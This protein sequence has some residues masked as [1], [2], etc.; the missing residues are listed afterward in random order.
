MI[1]TAKLRQSTSGMHAINSL[2]VRRRAYSARERGRRAYSAPEQ[3]REKVVC[4]WGYA[5]ARL[6]RANAGRCICRLILVGAHTL[7]RLA[8]KDER[9]VLLSGEDER[10]ALLGQWAGKTGSDAWV[11]RGMK[12]LMCESTIYLFARLA[13]RWAYRARQRMAG[14]FGCVS[15]LHRSI[16]NGNVRAYNQALKASQCPVDLNRIIA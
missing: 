6:G 3:T 16:M 11:A 4:R 15:A 14:N 10:T 2:P 1:F 12:R 13:A 5:T 7:C 9:T 8:K